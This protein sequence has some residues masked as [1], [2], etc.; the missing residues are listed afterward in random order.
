MLHA[1]ICF[2][3]FFFFLR[4]LCLPAGGG[5][6]GGG[7]WGD[8]IQSDNN[9]ADQRQDKNRRLLLRLLHSD[10]WKSTEWQWWDFIPCFI[11]K[12]ALNC[13]HVLTSSWA[14][15]LPAQ[16][17]F[18]CLLNPKIVCRM[19]KCPICTHTLCQ[20]WSRTGVLYPNEFCDKDEG[21]GDP[22][23]PLVQ[24]GTVT[25]LHLL[26]EGNGTCWLRGRARTLNSTL[27]LHH[28]SCGTW[29]G[30][31]E[32]GVGGK[33]RGHST[34]GDCERVGQHLLWA[35]HPSKR[36]YPCH[37]TARL[38]SEGPALH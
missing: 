4:Y 22:T 24:L 17:L 27:W 32:D 20:C 28:R 36:G 18:K 37:L 9:G 2:I 11:L 12:S 26:I 3:K 5:L 15:F 6:S 30:S 25:P 10:Q 31:G 16:L 21:W 13:C 1:F 23:G 29:W 34:S 19:S 14:S 7:L 33:P 38:H 8:D 35:F